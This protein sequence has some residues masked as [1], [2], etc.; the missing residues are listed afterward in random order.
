MLKVLLTALNICQ[1]VAL[2]LIPDRTAGGGANLLLKTPYF[3][4]LADFS[5]EE[6]CAVQSDSGDTLRVPQVSQLDSTFRP[7]RSELYRKSCFP[8]STN[9]VGQAVSQAGSKQ[10]DSI[11]LNILDN[12]RLIWR[13]FVPLCHTVLLSRRFSQF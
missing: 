6:S 11:A 1:V 7:Q 4:C 9:C 3:F 5:A 2:D 10:A 12:G 13:H 8:H